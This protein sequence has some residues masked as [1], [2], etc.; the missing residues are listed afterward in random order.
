MKVMIVGPPMSGKSTLFSAITGITPDP[1]AAPDTHPHAIVT[2][3]DERLTYLTELCQPKTTIQTTLEL[4][5]IPGCSLDDPKGVEEWRRH[6]P[7]VR[8]ADLLV[9]VV[10][11]F[12]ND[13]VPAFRNRVDALADFAV[14]WDELIFADLDTVTN[15]M[16]KIEKALT[17]PTKTH[18]EEKR[19]LAL[20]Q[21]CREALENEAPLSTVVT[22]EDE[23]RS[24][25]AF[26]MLTQK[27][28]VCVRN[29]SDDQAAH[30]TPL[31]VEHVEASVALSAAIEA[32]LGTLDA[33]DRQPFLDDLGLDKLARDRL[34][35]TCYTAGG[36]ISFLTMGPDEV[37]AWPIRKGSTAVEAAG[38]IHTD[39]SRGFIRAETVAYDDL[40]A[41]TDMK[42]AKAAGKVRKEGKTYVVQDG[43]IMNILYN[44]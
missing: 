14:M 44:A 31:E 27:P 26:A 42:G 10:R 39:L 7:A 37:R 17:K 4:W 32:E 33:E 18:D 29:V 20:L 35:H 16:Q 19:E 38:R 36:L 21:R 13:A 43:D 11:D 9:V 24:L 15:R 28:L 5:D 41:H 2:V 25:K 30:A 12:Q 23:L 6:L 1:Y 22:T 34:V 3:P 8:Q 40:V